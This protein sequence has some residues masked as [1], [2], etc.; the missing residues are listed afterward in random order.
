MTR[1]LSRLYIQL[2]IGILVGILIGCLFPAAGP[3][4]KPLADIFIKLIKM[5]LAPIIF[6]TVVIGIAKMGDLKT[7]GRVGVISLRGREMS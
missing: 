5:L 7:V 3:Y 1:L 4:L 2:L 6:A